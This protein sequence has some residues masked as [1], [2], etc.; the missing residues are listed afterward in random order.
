MKEYVS[1][2]DSFDLRLAQG[3]VTQRRQLAK[4]TAWEFTDENRATPIVYGPETCTPHRTK[5]AKHADWEF[6]FLVLVDCA[7]YI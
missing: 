7:A 5:S 1:C 2:L 4:R 6:K 3:E